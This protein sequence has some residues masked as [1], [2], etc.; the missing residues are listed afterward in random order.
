MENTLGCLLRVALILSASMA[1]SVAWADSDN[2][3]SECPMEV[4]RAGK[5]LEYL[6]AK[7]E[8]EKADAIA[9]Q[10]PNRLKDLYKLYITMQACYESRKEF[11]VQ[12]VSRQEMEAA[13]AITRRDE[14]AL[15]RQFPTL[16]TKKDALWEEAK[17]EYGASDFAAL[18]GVS[19]TSHSPTADRGC[20]IVATK[21]TADRSHQQQQIKKDF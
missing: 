9:N 8:R 7:V 18:L 13:R 3:Y 15:L 17:E 14:Q 6:D 12:Y 5:C 1:G 4:L 10:P 21:Y 16:R 19:G 20:K 11:Q 2:P